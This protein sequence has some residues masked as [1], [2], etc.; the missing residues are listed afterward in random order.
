MNTCFGI[1]RFVWIFCCIGLIFSG[2]KAH[3][4]RFTPNGGQWHQRVLYRADMPQGRVF[5][6]QNKFTYVVYKPTLNHTQTNSLIF[7]ENQSPFQIHV[8]NLEWLGGNPSP[9]TIS[10]KVLPETENFFIG[11][12]QSKW[13][14]GLHPAQSVLYSEVYNG[15]S[16]R[17]TSHDKSFKYEF[18]VQPG[19]DPNQIRLRYN[20][21]NNISIQNNQLV[22][23]TAIGKFYEQEPIVW[24]VV[25]GEKKYLRCKYRLQDGNITFSIDKHNPKLPLI[26]D[27]VLVFA[28]FTGS[29]AD[30][31]GFTA[32]YDNLGNLY[33]GGLVRGVGFP[34]DVLGP[35]SIQPNYAGGTWISFNYS[36][37]YESDIAI[38]KY[39]SNGQQRVYSTYLGGSFNEQPHSI[40]VNDR[41]ELY[42]LGTTRSNNFPVFF[43]SYDNS[44]NGQID[45]IVAKFDS[46]GENLL[47]STYL[48]G[49]QEDGI[50][51]KDITGSTNPN[52][53]HRFYADDARGEII[54]DNLGY[55][56]V[57]TSSSSP[58]FP[59]TA[60]AFQSNHIEDQDGVV[61]KLDPLMRQLV[62][63]S[64]LGGT[65][66]DAGYSLTFDQGNTLTVVGGT[67]S[68]DFPITANAYSDSYNGGSA[69]GF[70]TRIR[71]DGSLIEYSTY[72]G[73]SSYDQIYF[74]KTDIDNNIYVTGQTEGMS[75]PI[76]T[77]VYFNPNSTQFVTKLNPTLSNI[78]YS[79]RF[80]SGRGTPDIT[81]SAFLVDKCENIYISGWGGLEVNGVRNGN[82]TGLPVTPNAMKSAT[83]GSD[84]YLIVFR[85]NAQTLYYATFFGGYQSAAQYSEGEHVDGGTSRFDRKGIVYQSVCGGCGG[86]FAAPGGSN[87]ATSGS[88]SP[89]NNSYNCNNLV[90]KIEFEL[91]LESV[92][93]E[94]TQN[95]FTGCS[96]LDIQFTNLSERYRSVLWDFGNG[97]TTSVLNPARTFTQPGIHTIKLYAI[98]SLSCNISDTI[99]K[100]IEVFAKP[101]ADFTT[102]AFACT[103]V[104]QF[105]NSSS[106]DATDFLWNFGDGNTSI[107]RDPIHTFAANGRYN[108]QLIASNTNG[109]RDTINRSLD[110]YSY[111]V[112]AFNLASS[113]CRLN[114]QFGNQTVGGNEFFWDFGNGQTSTDSLPS[115]I[116][117]A[118]G[119]YIVS[120]RVNGSTCPVTIQD[121]IKIQ[122]ASVANFT[123]SQIPCSY[124]INFTNQT[125][126]ATT[127]L[128]N[129]GDGT[130]D[131]VLSPTHTF[132]GGG[133]Y[134][135][136]LIS[137]KD[138]YCADTFSLSIT[139][140]EIPQARFR[141]VAQKC[142]LNVYFDNT[143]S[144]ANQFL[145]D[146]GDGTTSNLSAVFHQYSSSGIYTVQLIASQ[147]N[148]CP[149]TTTL[150]VEISPHSNAQFI[151]PDSTCNSQVT[152]QNNSINYFSQQWDFGDGNTDT[153]RNPVHTYTS[154]GVYQVQLITDAGTLCADTAFQTVVVRLPGTARYGIST[155]KCNTKVLFSDSSINH[156]S[157]F[158][159]FDDATTDTALN[160]VHIF[161]GPG[162]YDVRLIVNRYSPCPDTMF[163][164]VVIDTPATAHF[165]VPPIV[166]DTF[167]TFFNTTTHGRTFLWDFGDGNTDTVFAPVHL[168]SGSGTYRV[169]LWVNQGEYCAD[170]QEVT[171]RIPNLSE[172]KFSYHA[173]PCDRKVTFENLSRLAGSYRWEFGDGTFSNTAAPV[174]TFSEAGSYTVQLITN[175]DSACSDTTKQVIVIW[176]ASQAD[177]RQ[178]TT[179]CDSV[180][181]FQ[182]SYPVHFSRS[183]HLSNGQSFTDSTVF[184]ALSPGFY[185]ITLL[186]DSGTACADTFQK[187]F[188][189]LPRP[190]AKFDIKQETCKQIITLQNTSIGSQLH[191]FWNFGDGSTSTEQNPIHHYNQERTYEISL[192]AIDANGCSDTTS[193][194]LEYDLDGLKNLFIPNVFTPNGDGRND[195][196][197]IF[198]ESAP[199]VESVMIFDRWG[200]L[201][202]ETNFYGN[203]WDG[204]V[205]GKDAQEGAYVYVIKG[206]NGKRAGTVTLIR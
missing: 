122:P 79:T 196:F 75:Y 135:V 42:I 200:I 150:A 140:P 20:G 3:D 131:S 204:T 193:F 77:G 143:S 15:I 188:Q 125:Q 52:P 41:N 149:D 55:C 144:A 105:T 190:Q 23:E 17:A 43:N 203:Y 90:F 136:Q 142:D 201:I 121:T 38:I 76:T 102:T 98:D 115:T 67:T 192:T 137:E 199:C 82:T 171:F 6:E 96:P 202:F 161:P 99:T 119:S 164:T 30:N 114:A 74:V 157:S 180:S 154:P 168:Y 60:G 18:I 104:V 160:P 19:A 14:S 29:Y 101:H 177:F 46:L 88:Y 92:L 182:A 85:K 21:L 197:E 71:N 94:F 126:N 73:T 152:F 12:D 130:Q 106:I 37:F 163:Q 80:G 169:R 57:V 93:S 176:P 13:V 134:A 178:L 100:T 116:Y 59:T 62:W 128:W 117:S 145:W 51:R 72:I 118:P 205:N 31:W 139:L 97:D 78:I 11:N 186:T 174:H 53:L 179:E 183:W 103:T 65:G 147:S 113:P 155:E 111:P 129:F 2:L 68:Q 16:L 61:F 24:Q 86:Q 36:L 185:T 40:I 44:F 173:E 162:R 127:Y 194:L 166:C 45:I 158:W 70:I 141:P 108:I 95:K 35:Y 151:A 87:P 191:Y 109:C 153:L 69:D 184:V 156:L 159:L 112:P 120:L 8:F 123:Y 175:P 110:V 28:T 48:G 138:I 89:V 50:N 63:S 133:T 4:L 189:I 81:M 148:A 107:Q 56:Y 181:I 25:K 7:P 187:D 39:N 58:D 47:G 54:V 32:T 27:P 33:S 132:P 5:L 198:A 167:V 66:I 195:K 22:L 26:I 170:S 172:A 146:F 64:F 49:S 10:E 165:F 124:T 9:K 83:D 1:S 34:V 84:F 206:R 91:Y